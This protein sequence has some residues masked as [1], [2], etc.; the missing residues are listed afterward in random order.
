MARLKKQQDE[1]KFKKAY[2]KP[3]DL[4]AN[5]KRVKEIPTKPQATKKLL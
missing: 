1:I 5:N 4:R 3:S 2:G